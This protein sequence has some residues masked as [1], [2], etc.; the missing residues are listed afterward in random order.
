MKL[1]KVTREAEITFPH[2]LREHIEARKAELTEGPLD[3]IRGAGAEAGRRAGSAVAGATRTVAGGVRDIAQAG[4]QAS[5]LGNLEKA[6]AQLAQLLAQ[7]SGGQQEPQVEPEAPQPPANSSGGV[8]DAFRTTEKPRARMGK[9]GPELTFNSYLAA[10]HGDQLDEG[11]WDFVKGAGAAVGSKIRNKI[12][13][14]A[15]TPSV[16]KDIY[17]AGMNASRA[18]N[19][20]KQSAAQTAMTGKIKQQVALVQQLAAKVGPQATM[21][22]VRK[23]GGAQAN[24]ITKL[25]SQQSTPAPS[26]AAPVQAAPTAPNPRVRAGAPVMP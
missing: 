4:A 11:I 15:E 10:T 17:S 21:A 2:S 6:I 1:T 16:L 24:A 9:Y 25:L 5:T 14:Y 3:F 26:T 7:T 13:K 19:A 8:P 20:K 12:N 18:G 22:A 23:A